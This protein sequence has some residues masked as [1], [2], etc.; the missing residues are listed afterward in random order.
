M[1]AVRIDPAI[2]RA[3]EPPMT[4]LKAQMAV[5]KDTG[6]SASL[7]VRRALMRYHLAQWNH[8]TPSQNVC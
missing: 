8:V 7:Q 1:A 6:T 3:S 5:L 2:D 4:P